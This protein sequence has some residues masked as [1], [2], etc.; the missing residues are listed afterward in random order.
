MN[1][2]YLEIP[3]RFCGPPNSGNGGYVCGLL[4]KHLTGAVTVRLKAPPPL[5]TKLRREWTNDSARLFHDS[6]VIG[7]AKTSELLLDPPNCPLSE[8]TSTCHSP[9]QGRPTRWPGRGTG[10]KLATHATA[11]L[12]A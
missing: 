9:G 3:E 8:S 11:L 6:A 2:E 12:P 7:E 4:A 10:V 5:K 1:T